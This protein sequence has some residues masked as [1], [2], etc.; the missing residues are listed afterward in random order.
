MAV[1][2][3]DHEL[4]SRS[5]SDGGMVRSLARTKDKRTKDKTNV[6]VLCLCSLS[7]GV[8]RSGAVLCPLFRGVAGVAGQ[9]QRRHALVGLVVGHAHDDSCP[10]VPEVAFA[11]PARRAGW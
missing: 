9:E 7:P 11:G 3:D 10:G 1:A 5:V 4:S 6:F 2:V 8:R